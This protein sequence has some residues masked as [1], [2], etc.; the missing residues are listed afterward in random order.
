[1]KRHESLEQLLSHIWSTIL[2]GAEDP[3]HPYHT[4]AFGTLGAN[5][6]MVRMVVLRSANSQDRTLCFHS[7]RRAQK[8][9]EI[10]HHKRV[11]WL[12]WD[13][14]NKE[15]LRLR[16]EASVHLSD[17][18]ADRLWEESSPKSLKLYVKPTEPGTSIEAPRSGIAPELPSELDHAQVAAGRKYFA[19]IRT[20]I[21]EIDFL[22]LHPEGNYRARFVWRQGW[23][24]QWIIP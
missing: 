1:M 9:Q 8:I 11:S 16:G 15:Q 22:H 21:D 10:H 6:A 19:A 18:L 23:D 17:R 13:A 5:D 4:L 14:E 12:L 24:S 3:A 2:Q 20:Q 7:D